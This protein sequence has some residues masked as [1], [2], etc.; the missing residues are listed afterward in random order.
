MDPV[1]SSRSCRRW[2]LTPVVVILSFWHPGYCNAMHICF[3][4]CNAL[5]GQANIRWCHLQSHKVY[6]SYQQHLSQT[7][8]PTHADIAVGKRRSVLSRNLTEPRLVLEKKRSRRVFPILCL[9]WPGS[10]CVYLKPVMTFPC[11][12]MWTDV[13][14]TNASHGGRK[15][16]N[17]TST[18]EAIILQTFVA[19]KFVIHM[20][21][22]SAALSVG[23]RYY[24]VSLRQPGMSSKT[25]EVFI[26]LTGITARN[27]LNLQVRDCSCLSTPRCGCKH[28]TFLNWSNAIKLQLSGS[29]ASVK[30]QLRY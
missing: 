14:Q 12:L 16:K 13:S 26:E 24:S 21:S 19:F 25:A 4:W 11:R 10:V 15:K 2:T 18:C 7:A 8:E 9:L 20:S 1:P 23:L 28:S 5:Y 22:Q 6:V 30:K 27:L 3:E 17:R 29:L